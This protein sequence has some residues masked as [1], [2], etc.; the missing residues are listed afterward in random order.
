MG[1]GQRRQAGDGADRGARR[2]ALLGRAMVV[3][4]RG[5]RQLCAQVKG[6]GRR[7]RLWERDER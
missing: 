5:V 4:G 7:W 2:N 1:R 3:M 6:D